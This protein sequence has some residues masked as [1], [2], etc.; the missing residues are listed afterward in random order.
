M[1]D[2]RPEVAEF[3]HFSAPYIKDDA[4]V[5]KIMTHM[6]VGLMPSLVLSGI[7]FGGRALMLTGFCILTSLLWEWLFCFVTKKKSSTDDLSA[8]VTGMIFAFMLPSNF[9]FWCA[10]VGTLMAIVVFKQLFGGLGR[11]I[12]NPAVASR[13]VCWFLF[14]SDFSKYLEPDVISADVETFGEVSLLSGV[15]AYGDMFL[16]RVCGG[17]GEVSVIALLT[18]AFYLLSTRVISLYEPIA[19]LGTVFCFSAAAG[20]DGVYQILAGGTVLAAFF[21]CSDSVTTPTTTLGKIIFGILAGGLT[22]VFRFFAHMPQEGM[23]IAILICNV[24]TI[25]IDRVTETRPDKQ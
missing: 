20:K 2:F 12:F 22:C 24:L 19:F 16:G 17:L 14:R 3:K 11:N 6:L 4:S 9:P 13:L 25:V 5:S 15:D 8:A 18:G 10:V 1:T 23:L 21:L 7:L